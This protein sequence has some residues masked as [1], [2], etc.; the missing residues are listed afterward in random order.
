MVHNWI[1]KKVVFTLRPWRLQ[2]HEPLR[3]LHGSG[4]RETMRE[5]TYT[6]HGCLFPI[7]SLASRYLL[8]PDLH[9]LLA[10]HQ[11]RTMTPSAK[12]IIVSIFYSY[13][14]HDKY[15]SSALNS[16]QLLH[17]RWRPMVNVSHYSHFSCQ[18]NP[19]SSRTTRTSRSLKTPRKSTIQPEFL[20]PHK[21]ENN[22]TRLI[23]ESTSTGTLIAATH[24]KTPR[25][26]TSNKKKKK[27]SHNLVTLDENLQTNTHATQKNS[28]K[29][30]FE[31]HKDS[32]TSHDIS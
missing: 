24:T 12:S 13:Q 10:H 22:D 1:T 21:T 5:D 19:I 23:Q 6:S 18:T 29:F 15:V 30:L 20:T 25:S 4:T 9:T 14:S 17:S 16:I 32:E 3:G 27:N 7:S 11:H 31:R 28:Q 26:K 2:A 8:A